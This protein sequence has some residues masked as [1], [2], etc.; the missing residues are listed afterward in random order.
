MHIVKVDA[1]ESTN[2]F[3]K[4]MCQQNTLKNFTVVI[5]D[6]Q[7]KGRGQMHASW[8]SEKGKNLTFSVLVQLNDLIIDQQFYISKI[9]SLAIYE[10]LSD[11]L[12]TKINIKWPND[13]LSAHQKICGVLIENSVKKTQVNHSIVGIGLNVNQQKFENL[14]QATSMKLQANTTFDLEVV[15]IDLIKTMKKYVAILNAKNYQLIDTLYLNHLYKFETPS[16]FKNDSGK[17]MGKIV[18]ISLQGKLQVELED[19]TIKEF[20][21]KE[22][23]FL[24]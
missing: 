3:L 23:E 12:T 15:L 17:F 21:L 22:I 24:N 4:E 10:V 13:I 6:E 2:T 16:M 18:G 11:L 8:Q 20:G 14:P 9:I 1:T 19:E 7:T 5:T